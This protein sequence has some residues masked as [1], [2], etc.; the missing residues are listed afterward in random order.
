M[1]LT[2]LTASQDGVGGRFI[3][4]DPVL[5]GILNVTPDSFSDGGWYVDRGKAVARA[6]EML[7]EGAKIIDIGGEST[8]PGSAPVR[9]D[10][11]MRR[12]VPVI[13]GLLEER[14]GT[15]ISIDTYRSATAEAA[16]EAG[17][18]VV[19]DVSGGTM[20]ERMLPLVARAG[21][22]VVLMHMKGEPKIMQHDPYYRDVV[23]EVRDH[24]AERAETA[25]DLGV[26]REN[27]VLDPG[28]GFGKTLL[29]NLALL[30]N[31]EEISGLGFPVLI[32]TSRKTFI[33]TL[34]GVEE[35]S[36][37]V[38]GTVATSVLAYERGA[39][40]FRVHDVRENREALQVAVAFER[41]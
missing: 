16:L 6:V 21:C 40:L 37:R 30:K 32:G 7:D 3:G 23:R 39:R 24:L 27:I 41:A 18:S 10:E 20:D 38:A 28:I 4:P 15:V 14:P 22:P 11:E 34:S 12:V 13:R 9:P 33:G 8:R 29:H 5:M 36:E 31:L 2:V 17:A 1:P 25:M 19:N 26:S 35:A